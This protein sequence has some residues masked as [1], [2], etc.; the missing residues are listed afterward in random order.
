MAKVFLLILQ[1]FS[2]NFTVYIYEENGAYLFCI[3]DS[4]MYS[5]KGCLVPLGFCA[6]LSKPSDG[7][8]HVPSVPPQFSPMPAQ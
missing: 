8:E 6:R 5:L 2:T 7:R 4:G 3:T 1:H